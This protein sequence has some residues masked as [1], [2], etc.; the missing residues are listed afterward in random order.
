MEFGNLIV[1]I[2]LTYFS[3]HILFM[4]FAKKTR[5]GVQTANKKLDELRT[6][7]I[8]TIEEQKEFINIKH[9]KWG[10][11]NWSWMMIPRVLP[12]LLS[13]MI[14]FYLYRFLFSHYNI[15]VRMWQAILFIIIFPLILNLI[16][17]KFNIQKGDLKVLL[18]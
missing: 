18:R 7:R 10:K 6:I 1:I 12:R 9:P 17:E 11:I 14:I 16:L 3:L 2:F 4:I 5:I 15:N 8:K 13:F